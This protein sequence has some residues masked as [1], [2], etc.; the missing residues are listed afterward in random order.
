MANWFVRINHR[1]GKA[2]ELFSEQAERKLYYDLD[3][4]KDVLAQIK[5]DYPEYFSEKVPQR[6]VESE[7]FY[8]NIYELSDYWE[9]YWNEEIPC[10][11]CGSNSVTRIDLKNYGRG[12]LYF[13]CHEHSEQYYADKLA[14]DTRTYREGEFVGFIYKITH[15]ETGR[16]YIGKTVNHPIFRW[17]QHFKAQSG[18]YFHKA[19]KNSKIT[20]WTY[21]VIDE[22]KEGSENDLLELESKYIADYNATDREYGFNTKD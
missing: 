17:F 18:S 12:N 6:T 15:K 3:T 19:M 14:E 1:K 22:L 2:G 21:E 13:C 8:V 11:Y 10:K 9:S 4:K 16:V 5:K 20:D 7:L